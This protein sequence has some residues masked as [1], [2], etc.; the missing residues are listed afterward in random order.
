MKIPVY[1]DYNATTPLDPHVAA[2]MQ[3]FLYD[4]F[5]NPSSGHPYGV[6]ARLAIETARRHVADMLNARED[7][8][9]FTGGGTEANNMA[10]RG[11]CLQNRARGNH[12]ITSAIEHPAVLEVC[13]ALELEGFR[14][15]VLPV[16]Q[17]GLVNPSDLEAALRP[18]TILVSVMHANNEVGTIQP[19]RELADIT[20]QAGAVFHC[21]AA[22]STGKIAVDV[23]QLGVDMLSLAG[24]KFYAPKGIGILYIRQGVKLAKVTQGANHENNRRPGTENTL[25]IAG[26]GSAALLVRTDLQR[27]HD[28]FARMRA[29]LASGLQQRLSD[30][31]VRING[32]PELHLPNT[33]SVSFRNL[34]ANELLL[35]LNSQVAASAGA[36]CH[37][38]QVSVSSVLAAMQVPVEWAI[39]T[40]RFSTGR[41]TT[42]SEIDFALDSICTAVDALTKKSS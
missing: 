14:L 21:D 12:I 7:E 24:H 11:Y 29:R 41:A 13:R 35:R 1:L 36:A 20:H 27:Y 23:E 37:A 19:V 33:L 42:A 10:I 34:H 32:H 25:A 26:L 30:E 17:Y 39:G 8:L 16:D 40:L 3:P 6:Q 4:Y 15:S 9:V 38:D 22:Q 28:H 18:E 5:G 31:R 2:A